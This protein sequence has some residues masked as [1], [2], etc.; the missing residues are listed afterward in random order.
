MIDTRKEQEQA[1]LDYFYGIMAEN[2]RTLK[3]ELL[4]MKKE[5]LLE[6]CDVLDKIAENGFSCTVVSKVHIGTLEV[7]KTNQI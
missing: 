2:K 1:D 6:F 5:D 3:K 4:E 7:D